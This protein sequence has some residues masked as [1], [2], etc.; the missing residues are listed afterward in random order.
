MYICTDTHTYIH[1]HICLLSNSGICSPTNQLACAAGDLTSKHGALLLPQQAGS[2]LRAVFTDS[3]LPLSG[4]GAVFQQTSGSTPL[5]LIQQMDGTMTL[6]QN[7]ICEPG[8]SAMLVAAPVEPP[9]PVTMATTMGNTPVPGT[10]TIMLHKMSI[11]MM[12]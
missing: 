2:S 9:P 1:T 11:V 10:N 8:G 3:N 12:T 4:P 6:P 7:V 5:L